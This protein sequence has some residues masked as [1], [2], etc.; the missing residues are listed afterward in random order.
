MKNKK[1]ISV[2][3]IKTKANRFLKDSD[4]DKA[5]ER[6]QLHFFVEG[7]LLEVGAYAGF[8]CLTQNQVSEGQTFGMTFEPGKDPVFHDKTRTFFI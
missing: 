7:L 8:A 1:T 3:F 6:K 5:E 2:E 4:N